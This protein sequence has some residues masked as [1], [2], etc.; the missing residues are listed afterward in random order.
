[1]DVAKLLLENAKRF[2]AKPAFIFKDQPITFQ[3]LRDISFQLTDSL[4]KL[5]IQKNDTIAIYLPNW[6]EYIYGYLA[7]F[8]IGAVVVPLD[9]MLTEEEVV[10]FLNHSE[11]KVLLAK[12]N[13]GMNFK[14]M[15]DS[16]GY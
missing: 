11:S 7:I 13:K 8:T 3:K 1:M 5:G 14:Q 12:E 10:N 9:F 15:K 4:L 6:P 2:P 16:L